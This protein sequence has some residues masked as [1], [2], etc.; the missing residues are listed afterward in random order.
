VKIL[1]II[2]SLMSGGKENLL[3]N[4]CAACSLKGNSVA[5]IIINDMTDP[6]IL[7]QLFAKDIHVT[8][9]GRT[10]GSSIFPALR[11]IRKQLKDFNPD[12][13]H[14]HEDLSSVLGVIATLGSKIK[15]AHTL[16]CGNM[17]PLTL[18]ERITKF[19]QG[20]SIDAFIAI[21]S[22]VKKDFLER[23]PVDANRVTVVENGVPLDRFHCNNKGGDR[24]L[25]VCVARLDHPIKGQDI[26][27]RALH[28]LKEKRINFGCILVGDGASAEYLKNLASELGITKDIEFSGKQSDVSKFINRASIAVV[29]SRH[30]G[31]G[32]SAIEAMACGRP[33]IASATGG[34]CDLIQ[35]GGNGLRF[36]TG[37]HNDLADQI[38]R[39]SEDSELYEALVRAGH[40]TAKRHSIEEMAWQYQALYEQIV[41]RFGESA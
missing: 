38:L 11:Q 20:R 37:D 32:I 31:F 33:V 18:K 15:R 21:S 25:I 1:H 27:L 34:L 23:C 39:L 36:R 8:R 41:N 2:S 17:Y 7:G 16:H 5:V 28:L 3:V 6:E 22:S 26:L 19:I 30:E 13:I 35:H 9:I 12:L 4:L 40:E 24:R 14:T 10:P 29:P